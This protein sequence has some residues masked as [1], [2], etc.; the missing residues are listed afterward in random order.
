M[1]LGHTLNNVKSEIITHDNTT[2]STILTSLPRAQMVHS[3]HATILGSPIGDAEY[4]LGHIIL[5]KV[6]M[7]KRVSEKFDIL[8]AHGALLLLE[9]SFIIP[10]LQYLLRTAPCYESP[11]LEGY[12][13]VL[14]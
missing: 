4:L 5:E 6:A 7:L 11:T 3:A 9:H 8:S 13:V 14:R 10:K 2:L 1:E 12:D